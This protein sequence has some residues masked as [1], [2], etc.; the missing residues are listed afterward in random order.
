MTSYLLGGPMGAGMQQQIPQ[1]SFTPTGRGGTA[2]E[3]LL[4]T[5]EAYFSLPGKQQL[6]QQMLAG[7]SQGLPQ[8]YDFLTRLLSGDESI[9]RELEAPALRQFQEQIVPGLAERYTAMGEG[10]QGSSA[11]QQQLAAAGGRL[12]QELAGQR[13]GYR[14]SALDRLLQQAGQTM[15]TSPYDLV[16]RTPGFVESGLQSLMQVLPL[17]LTLRMGQGAK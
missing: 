6:Y 14:M 8:S 9:Y 15:R 3:F 2:R 11:Y 12:A 17:G 16:P 1:P 4:G 5:P 13:T 7:T 10:G